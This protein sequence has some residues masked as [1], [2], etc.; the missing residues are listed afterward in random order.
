MSAGR[1]VEKA[2]KFVNLANRRVNKAI[3]DLRLIANLGNRSHYA[4]D[5]TQA[6]KIVKALQK[7]VDA[8]KSALLDGTGGG[9]DEFRL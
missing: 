2:D 4:Y 7:E 8:V 5:A 1:E 3:K 6:R 9:S